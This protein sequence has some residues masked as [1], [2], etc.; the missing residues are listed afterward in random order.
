MKSTNEPPAGLSD[1]EA[2]RRT[3][4]AAGGISLS[5]VAALTGIPGSTVQ[6]WVKR[7]LAPASAGKRYQPKH[8]ARFL[9]ID[10]LRDALPLDQILFLLTYM[11]GDLEDVTDDRI[12]DCS[13]YALFCR[14]D[15][16]CGGSDR[17]AT[18]RQVLALLKGQVVDPLPV[19]KALTAMLL[20]KRAA[21]MVRETNQCL[22]LLKEEIYH[23][24]KQCNA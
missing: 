20:A 22:S 23:D 13:L 7:G 5:Q 21:A 17:D 14:A 3:V 10:R 15:E 18:E 4:E 16:T 8:L 1:W 12:D 2:I 9:L 11:N 6:N 24:R 19:A